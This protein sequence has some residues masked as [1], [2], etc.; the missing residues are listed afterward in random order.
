MAL[1]L[2][3]VKPENEF[4]VSPPLVDSGTILRTN[5]GGGVV[6]DVGKEPGPSPKEF[7][8]QQNYSNPFLQIAGWRILG[9]KKTLVL[10]IV[11]STIFPI[12]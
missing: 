1:R 4:H 6:V 9:H 7:L 12:A 10:E 11:S 8:L 2:R 5:N 3:D